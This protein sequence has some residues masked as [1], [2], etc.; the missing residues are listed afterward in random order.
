MG[1]RWTEEDIRL[2][3]ECYE[4]TGTREL[5]KRL[6]RTIGSVHKQAEKLGIKKDEQFNAATRFGPGER[7]YK[8]KPIGSTHRFGDGYTYVKTGDGFK[9]LHH[10]RWKEKHGEYPAPG[11]VVRFK[12]GNKENS[13]PENLELITRQQQLADYTVH[14]LPSELRELVM[15]KGKITFFMNR[16]KK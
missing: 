13:D 1:K 4:N 12:D 8:R 6:G 15:L 9:P 14:N 3:R 2:M 5:A 16:R 11:M 10:V 7:P